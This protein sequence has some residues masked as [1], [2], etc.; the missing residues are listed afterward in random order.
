MIQLYYKTINKIEL[1]GRSLFIGIVL[2]LTPTKKHD[3]N[4]VFLYFG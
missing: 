1:I 3:L 2:N 4:H